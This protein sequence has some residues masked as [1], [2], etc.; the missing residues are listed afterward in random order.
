MMRLVALI[1]MAALATAGVAWAG[2]TVVFATDW[3]A[4]AEQGGFYQALATGLYAKRGL[5]VR[6]HQGGPQ[7]NT[8]QLIAAGAVDL[9]MGSNAFIVANFVQ[10]GAPVKAVM[11]SF[12]KDPQVL[13]CHPREDIGS[14]ADM[15]GKPIM[16]AKDSLT[17]FWPWLKQKYGFTDAQIRPYTFNMAPFLVDAKAIQEGYLGSEPYQI[18]KADGIAPKV[19]LLADAGYPGYAAMVVASQAL[20]EGRPDVVRAFVAASI[21]GWRDYLHG[22]PTPGNRLIKQNNPDMTDDVIAYGIVAMKEHGLVEGGDA[23]TLGIGVM[24]DARWAAFTDTMTAVGVYPKDL[25]IRSGYTLEFLP[26][27]TAAVRP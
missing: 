8:P 23:S 13:I 25:D 16:L 1:A 19:F 27:E 24:T 26:R 17:A 6:I 21:E 20:I 5:D 11:A 7:S 4:Q 3:T 12:Q 18:A 2:E 10:A 15:K 14:I 9:A 22:D